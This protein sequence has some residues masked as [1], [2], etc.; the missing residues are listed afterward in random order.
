[1]LPA[2][3]SKA[4]RVVLCQG[5]LF[6]DL[7][8]RI[9]DEERDLALVRLE[10]CYPFPEDELRRELDRLGA[11]EIVW[12]QEEP[13]NMGAAHFVVRNLRT[14]LGIEARVIAR[15]ESASPATGSMTL[16]KREQETLIDGILEPDR[17]AGRRGAKDP[18]AD[19]RARRTGS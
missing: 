2:A 14:R 4:T 11:N 6:Y 3:A 1:V 9:A 15:P 12:A 8:E 19:L 18:V 16:H 10:R 13:E 17:T 7:S 5:K